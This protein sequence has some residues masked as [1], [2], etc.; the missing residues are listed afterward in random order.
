M[1][2]PPTDGPSYQAW[3]LTTL[4]P[5]KQIDLNR[6]HWG[7]LRRL[8]REAAGI[9]EDLDAV[10]KTVVYN[11]PFPA[12]LNQASPGA[13]RPVP[14]DPQIIHAILGIITEAG[15]LAQALL[16]TLFEGAELDV[17]NLCEESGDIDW[18]QALLD[19]RIGYSQEQRWADN[20]AKL[21]KRYT[22]TSA[23]VRFTSEDALTRDT[24]TE[25]DVIGWVDPGKPGSGFTAAT[26]VPPA[27]TQDETT[28]SD[29]DTPEPPSPEGTPD[30]EAPEPPSPEV[31]SGVDTPESPDETGP[32][33]DE[34]PLDA[35]EDTE[36][37]LT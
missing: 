9:A 21:E 35:P 10:K 2:T 33:E 5:E 36:S 4:C 34:D 22:R 30:V 20:I 24:A 32:V 12:R 27:E 29:M 31:T 1:T 18:Y 28:T 15:E 17:R 13:P 14:I 6:V 19:S 26:V 8:L 16:T 7:T 11:K 25:L 3:A 37:E 23:E